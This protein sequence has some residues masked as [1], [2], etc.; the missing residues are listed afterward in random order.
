MAWITFVF[1][2]CMHIFCF[3]EPTIAER[4]LWSYFYT[5]YHLSLTIWFILIM[6]FGYTWMSQQ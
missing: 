1:L 3:F 5:L 2:V 4:T 6:A